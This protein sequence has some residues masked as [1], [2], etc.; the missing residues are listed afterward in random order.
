MSKA[1]AKAPAVTVK[2]PQT[3]DEA[4]DFVAEIGKK[5]RV[6]ALLEGD[7]NEQLAALRAKF[8][9]EAL[10]YGRDI[11]Q[12]SEGLSIWAAAHRDELTRGGKTKTAV[13]ASGEL[14]WRLTPPAV[15]LRNVK[16]VLA[17]LAKAK[18]GRFIRTKEEVDKEAIL[19]EP[20]AVKS[21]AGISVGQHEEFVIVPNE[22]KL[23]EIA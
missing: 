17:A 15:T 14:R 10:R 21:I 20:E 4:R 9:G 16:D 12:L 2:V 23:E 6:R 3:F 1:K 7:M 18:L 5:Q 11:K 19:K 8:E 13:L 22:T